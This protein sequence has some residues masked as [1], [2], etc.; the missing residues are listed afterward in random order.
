MSIISFEQ[1]QKN[2]GGSTAAE[3]AVR[4]NNAKVKFF[5]GKSKRPFTTLTALDLALGV[6]QTKILKVDY[7]GTTDEIEVI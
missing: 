2:F 3:V 7:T 4:L 5:I 1:L 6:N